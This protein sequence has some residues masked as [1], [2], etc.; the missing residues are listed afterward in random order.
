[1]DLAL[2]NLQWLICHKTKPS[3]TKE[4]WNTIQDE[5]RRGYCTIVSTPEMVD[6]VNVLILADRSVRIEDISEQQGISVGTVH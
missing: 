1:M 2:N 4:G 6:S 5:A 3:N